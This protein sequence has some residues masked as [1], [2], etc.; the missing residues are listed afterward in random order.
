MF[1]SASLAAHMPRPTVLFRTIVVVPLLALTAAGQAPISNWDNLRMLA[2]GTEVRVVVGAANAVNGA[3]ESMTDTD[4][5]ILREG[6]G[7]Q[8]FE[9]T[10]IASVSVEKVG[11]R[12]RDTLIGLGVGLVAGVVAGLAIRGCQTDCK[13]NQSPVGYGIGIGAPLGAVVGVAW[14]TGGWRKVYQ[15][16][17]QPR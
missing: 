6:A 13:P 14:P 7:P 17:Y 12:G 2:A 8:S 16:F 1:T 15:H 4:V 3:L 5:V 10:Q 11:H 9:R